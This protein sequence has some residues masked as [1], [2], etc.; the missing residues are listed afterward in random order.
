VRHLAPALPTAVNWIIGISLFA[1]LLAYL[2]IAL[3]R[4]YGGSRVMTGVKLVVLGALYAV[5]FGASQPLII[6]A[7]LLQF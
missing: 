3:R 1:W 6:G 2:P 5:A 4:V 7:A